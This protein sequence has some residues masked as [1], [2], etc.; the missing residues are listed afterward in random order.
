LWPQSSLLAFKQTF[1]K[2]WR[3]IVRTSFRHLSEMPSRQL[4]ARNYWNPIILMYKGCRQMM[5]TGKLALLIAAAT[6]AAQPLLSQMSPSPKLTFDVISIKPAAPL[7]SAGVIGGGT[8]GNRFTMVSSTLRMLLQRAYQHS[9]VLLQVVGEPSWIDSDRYDIQA[10]ANCSGGA[11]SSEQIQL[12]V[13]SMLEDRFQLKA[14]MET[15]YGQVYNL[16]VAKYP[17][18]IKLSED[19][20]PIPRRVS[21]PIQPCSPVPEPPANAAAPPTPRAG[22]RGSPFDPDNPAPRGFLGISFSPSRVTLRGSAVPISSM[23]GMLQRYVGSMIIEKTDLKGLFDF[24]IRFSQEG[25]VNTDGMPL[26]SPDTVIPA[27]V[28]IDRA[29]TLFTAIQEVG[30]KLEPGQ[31]AG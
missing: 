3:V 25:L 16:V 26:A 30:L 20:T 9:V 15:R 31:R 22:Q 28:V 14:H 2:L 10:T 21:A 29:S 6:F 23:L 17:P 24:T 19:Q 4:N 27:G 13:R 12:M 8:R 7:S 5:R 1:L 11:L 18:K